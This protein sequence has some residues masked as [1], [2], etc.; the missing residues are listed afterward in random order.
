MAMAQKQDSTVLLSTFAMLSVNSAKH[1]DAHLEMRPDNDGSCPFL[2]R[3]CAATATRSVGTRGTA[4]L[5]LRSQS[6]RKEVP[7]ETLRCGSG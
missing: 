4:R 5:L 3:C 1:L 6:G 2:Q 7:R